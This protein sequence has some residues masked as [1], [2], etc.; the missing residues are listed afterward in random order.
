MNWAHSLLKSLPESKNY[1]ASPIIIEN[2][3]KTSDFF[4]L[5]NPF[6]SKLFKKAS[7]SNSGFS[8]I[9]K[10]SIEIY[11]RTVKNYPKYVQFKAQTLDV[12][13][14]HAHF[15]DAGC[16]FLEL[17]Q[18]LNIPLVV[19]FYGADFRYLPNIKPKYKKWYRRLFKEADCFIALGPYGAETLREM[20][21]PAAKIRIGRLGVRV[22]EIPFFKRDKI[23]NN[24][25][26]VLAATFTEKKGQIYAIRAFKKTLEECPDM[27]LTLAGRIH[28]EK[29]EYK[30]FV[31]DYIQANNLR[32]RVI[33]RDAVD[34]GELYDFLK[35]FDVLIH[36]SCHSK[37]GD[38]EGTPF[39]LLDAQATGMPILTTNHADIP[40]EMINGKTGILCPEKNIE[41]LALGIRQF[42]EMNNEDYSTFAKNARNFVESEFDIRKNAVSIRKIYEE[43]TSTFDCSKTY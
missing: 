38:C 35:G 4:F 18:K 29:N 17:R 32:E 16:H 2:R 9:Q 33:V 1:I 6:Q 10:I 7:L 34:Y 40:S 23:K 15:G 22:Q 13:I 14:L 42:Y 31:L 43:I 5:E 25:K 26:L 3:F 19:S 37:L 28:G 39:A 12:N 36:P 8:L 11:N 41:E 24:L 21:C 30:K 27:T 20:G